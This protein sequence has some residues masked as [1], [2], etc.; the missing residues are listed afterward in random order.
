MVGEKTFSKSDFIEQEQFDDE[1]DPFADGD[2]PEETVQALVEAVTSDADEGADISDDTDLDF[3]ANSEELAKT[4]MD[5]LQEISE[6]A[7]QNHGGKLLP[8]IT[9]EKTTLIDDVSITKNDME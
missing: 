7:L 2:S 6:E 8:I 9:I 3:H 4:V 1:F 5:R